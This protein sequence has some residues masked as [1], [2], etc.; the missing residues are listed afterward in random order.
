MSF[1]V[2]QESEFSEHPKNNDKDHNADD[3]YDDFDDNEGI[4][5]QPYH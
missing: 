5:R 1:T 3:D 4:G 2:L